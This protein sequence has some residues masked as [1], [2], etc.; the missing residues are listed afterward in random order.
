M[1][2]VA[3]AFILWLT[4]LPPPLALAAA[5]KDV[6][7]AEA[8]T[9]IDKTRNI[10]ILDVR[11]P[12][13]RSQG[14]IPGSQL[15]PIDTIQRRLAEIP[16]NRPIV[17]YCAVGSRSRAAAQGLSRLGYPEVYNMRDGIMG[18]YRSGYPIQR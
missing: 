8:K 2:R 4:I 12:Q 14:Y 18:W 15:I 11:S 7:A 3:V 13:E 6:S 10:F 5:A 17:V 1:K 16:K 9:I